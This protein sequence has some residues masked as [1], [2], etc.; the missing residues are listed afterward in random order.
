MSGVDNDG[1]DVVGVSFKRVHFLKSVV[2]EDSD[3]HVIRT[4]HHP[5]LSDNKLSSTD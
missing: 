3:L 4:C 1:P 5:A 2:V